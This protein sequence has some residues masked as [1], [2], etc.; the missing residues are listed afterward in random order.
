MS[1]DN[2]IHLINFTSE[3]LSIEQE[4][5]IPLIRNQDTAISIDDVVS[6][7]NAGTF[8]TNLNYN[9]EEE[10]QWIRDQSGYGVAVIL[11]QCVTTTGDG[12]KD[13]EH[14]PGTVIEA[15]P[16]TD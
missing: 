4:I 5:V 9:R 3:G 1:N 12:Y 8:N 14:S 2:N 13:F 15:E 6:G 11:S 16:E 7:L 10:E